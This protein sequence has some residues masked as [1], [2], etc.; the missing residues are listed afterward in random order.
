M[1]G[2]SP[3]PTLHR[4]CQAQAGMGVK[5][6]REKYLALERASEERHEYLDGRCYAMAGERPEHGTICTNLTMLIASLLR[7]T[8][9]QA[10]AKD[11]NFQQT[12]SRH[13]LR[14]HHR[15]D[16]WAA[17]WGREDRP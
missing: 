9:Y 17:R 3:R 11:T 15:S 6:T 8:P 5:E 1:T 16:A 12:H 7:D 13:S 2:V 14:S 4:T 10:W